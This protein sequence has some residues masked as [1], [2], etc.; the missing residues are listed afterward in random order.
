[1]ETVNIIVH[2]KTESDITALKSFMKDQNIEFEISNQLNNVL[3]AE[4]KNA[5]EMSLKYIKQFGT[6]EHHTVMEETKKRY[7]NFFDK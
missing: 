5:I 2:A 1:M 7:P 3:S 6:E 4:Q